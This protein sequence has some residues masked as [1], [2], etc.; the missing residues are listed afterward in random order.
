MLAF[1]LFL[2]LVMPSRLL[3]RRA[4]IVLVRMAVGGVTEVRWM[5]GWRECRLL[6]KFVE[7]S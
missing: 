7:V 2:I 1:C 5:P 4:Q 6:C 3:S